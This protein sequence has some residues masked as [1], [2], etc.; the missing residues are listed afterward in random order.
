MPMTIA[1]LDALSAAEAA[2]E[3]RACC[4]SSEW[5]AG[6]L[7][8]RP[9]RT[10]ESL[11]RAADEVWS[12]LGPADWLEAFAH[13]PRIGERRAAVAAGK[14]AE[15]WSSA[16]QSGATTAAERTKEAL[17]ERN[18]A[19]E[20]RFGFI[21]VICAT[22]LTGAAMLAALESRMHNEPAVEQRVAAEEQGKI[23][24]LRLEKLVSGD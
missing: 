2:A 19:Y 12:R 16:E 10:R 20:S 9:F 18:R 15:G 7:A 4:G 17:A 23:T 24:R 1:Q 8:R 22:G 5:V 14:A 21:F 13:H 11:L 3:L 6:M